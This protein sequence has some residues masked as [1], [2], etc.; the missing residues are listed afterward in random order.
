M[1]VHA[2]ILSGGYGTRL[3]PA[4][5]PWRP[6][7]FLPL[8]ARTSMFQAT[9]AR[10]AAVTGGG[11]AVVVAGIGHADEIWRQLG[12]LGDQETVLLV[13]P[14]QR[15]SGPAIAAAAA[16]IQ[17]RDPDGVGVMVASDH[18]LPDTAAFVAAAREAAELAAG[19]AIVTF[20]VRPSCASTA[21][22]YIQPGDPLG[23]A[24]GARHVAQFAEKP[25]AGLAE[26]YLAEGWLWNS[27]NFVFAARALM[28]DFDL[29]APE[30]AQAARAAV[31]GLGEGPGRHDLG[32]AF[33]DAPKIS[34]DYAV[35]EK[36][37][38]AAVIP[39][40][41]AWSDLGAWDAVHAALD[42]DADDN[43]VPP[44]AVLIGTRSSLVRSATAQTI[45]LVGLSEVAVVVE[46]DA[47]LVA[48]LRSSQRV[49]E[50]VDALPPRTPPAS[51]TAAPNPVARLQAQARGWDGWLRA[52]ALPLWWTLG[53]DAGRPAFA[54]AITQ[55]VRPEFASHRLRVQ[56]RQ[57]Y[58]YA[59]AG[60][61]GWA[62]PWRGA[63]ALGLDSLAQRHRRADGAY[64]TRAA[65]DGSAGDDTA[66]LYDQAFVLLALAWAKRTGVA[67][68]AEAEAQ[69]LL[70]TVIAPWRNPAGGFREAD[71]ERPWQSNPHMHL[72][73]ACLAWIE[74]GGGSQWA[75][76]AEEI[77]ALALG[78]FIDPTT[79]ALRE[80]FT[81][82]WAPAP[83]ADGRR[84]EPGHQ[85]EW[86]WLLARWAVLGGAPAT[87]AAAERLYALAV[88]RGVDRA[89]GVAINALDDDLSMLDPAARLWPQTERLKAA[90]LL[91]ERASGLARAERLIEAADA[92]DGL[93]LY[94]ADVAPGLWRDKLQADGQFVEEPA[95]ASSLYHI[96]C[97]I[98]EL[99]AATRRL[100]PA[101]AP[102]AG[103]E[104]GPSPA[105]RT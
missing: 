92:A 97:A 68:D 42:R 25:A 96:A 38:R 99:V 73:E 37:R 27:G 103:L 6:K 84:V 16:W 67:P 51:P 3:W 4:S 43:A 35:M 17:R 44:G 77:C 41:T 1:A 47:I 9:V 69:A 62:G 58:V 87:A 22:G 26:R 100:A 88:S 46:A 102:G 59:L 85:F 12:E 20:G 53:A 95:P 45:A 89:R 57:T 33:L 8:V 71:P 2:I 98:A 18:H 10:M 36:T 39:L 30:I 66:T 72:F 64:R 93:A 63:V 90:L 94:V 7:Q 13:E 56:A 31:E 19:G 11:S 83:G 74:A 52:A 14:G 23:P 29:Y 79:G 34:I 82:D 105:L 32:A 48:D 78:K 104:P 21:Y 55:D 28:E 76:L 75:A 91:A 5:R 24:T 40:D 81:S 86:A 101:D 80:F 49:K 15:D 54:D 60:E 70:R 61:L 50:V 65:G